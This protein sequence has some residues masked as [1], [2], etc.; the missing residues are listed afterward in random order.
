MKNMQEF[1]EWLFVPTTVQNHLTALTNFSLK[2]VN[3]L[4]SFE[5]W[6]IWG[7]LEVVK[8]A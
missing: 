2:K 5:P 3:S 6:Y 1:R 8:Q 7:E 4:V